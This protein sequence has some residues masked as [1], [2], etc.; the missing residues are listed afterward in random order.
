MVSTKIVMYHN[1]RCSKSRLALQLLQEHGVEVETVD[2]LHNPPNKKELKHL[3][4]LLGMDDP[5]ELMRK[6][7]A[8]YAEQGLDD[9]ELTMDAMVNTMI[10]HPILIQRPII[11]ANG[12]AFVARPPENV[13][14]M[15]GID[16][17]QVAGP[18]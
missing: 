9:P 2:Y 16:S 17:A 12:K 15:L 6:N 4:K 3:L 13:L 11:I 1:P 8:A 10:Q 5:R 7:E 18:L 14:I